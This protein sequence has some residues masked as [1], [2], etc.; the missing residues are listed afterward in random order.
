M[1]K[2]ETKE[3]VKEEVKEETENSDADDAEALSKIQVRY[4]NGGSSLP[5]EPR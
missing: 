1:S 5:T 3:E 2:E 4:G